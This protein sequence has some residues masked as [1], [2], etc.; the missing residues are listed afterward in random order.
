MAL[1][2][3]RKPRFILI[4]GIEVPEPM[5]EAPE[6][7]AVYHIVS[8]SYKEGNVIN[9]VWED[10][11][12]SRYWLSLGL[13]HLTRESAEIHAQALLSFTKQ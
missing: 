4:N 3:R 13:C 5:R 12:F 11:D 9:E 8:F 1:E 10:D 7:G 2:W 6:V